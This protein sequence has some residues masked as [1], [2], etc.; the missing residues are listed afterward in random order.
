MSKTL[1]LP[2][3]KNFIRSLNLS[4][5]DLIKRYNVMNHMVIEEIK[6]ASGS[7]AVYLEQPNPL[8]ILDEGITE[9][10]QIIGQNT[11]LIIGVNP[12]S[13]GVLEAPG[14]YGAD[15]VVGEGQPLGV[16]MT[17]GGPIYGIF[18]CSKARNFPDLPIP[19]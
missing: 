16:G 8:G 1:S 14:N 9:I 11:A 12:T 10:K 2:K 7:C 15:I 6:N 3:Y 17:A 5:N 4:S 18:A 19:H 13:L